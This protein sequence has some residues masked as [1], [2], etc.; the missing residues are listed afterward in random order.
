M[1][2]VRCGLC[3][4]K[5]L[6]SQTSVRIVWGEE[7]RFCHM[8]A[9][10]FDRAR[11]MLL[12]GKKTYSRCGRRAL[13]KFKAIQEGQLEMLRKKQFL[14]LE[15]ELKDKVEYFG[16]QVALKSEKVAEK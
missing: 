5:R 14:R 12:D 6:S 3:G 9:R 13:V 1:Y 16:K 10:H 2:K 11:Q 4:T 15:R 7:V 8:C